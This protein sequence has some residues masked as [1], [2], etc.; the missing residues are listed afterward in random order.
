MSKR[1]D[2]REKRESSEDVERLHSLT[3]RKGRLEGLKN[4]VRNNCKT[5]S[6]SAKD[7]KHL[8]TGIL[9]SFYQHRWPLPNLSRM[10]IMLALTDSSNELRGMG[11]T[12]REFEVELPHHCHVI[13]D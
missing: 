2:V 7:N 6:G 1:Q 4:D 12:S 9:L 8:L 11:G 13:V 10:S 3:L 5:I